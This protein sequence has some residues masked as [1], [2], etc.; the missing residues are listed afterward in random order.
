MAWSRGAA[1]GVAEDS[2]FRRPQRRTRL[3]LRNLSL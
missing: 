1:L 2:S 3:A